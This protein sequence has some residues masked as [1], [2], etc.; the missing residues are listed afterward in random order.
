[1]PPGPQGWPLPSSLPLS[2]QEQEHVG[3]AGRRY[4]TLKTFICT[5]LALINIGYLYNNF[6]K[7]F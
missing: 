7:V 1:M 6:K 2:P 3:R 4:N 5:I